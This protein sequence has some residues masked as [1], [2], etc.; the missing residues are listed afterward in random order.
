MLKKVLTDS[1][2]NLDD[3]YSSKKIMSFMS[4]NSCLFMAMVDMFTHY[5]IN[6]VVFSS[7]LVMAGGQSLLSIL[8][9]KVGTSNGSK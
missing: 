8:G 7:F 3:R 9:N 1:L 4:F 6:E 5:K 2:T